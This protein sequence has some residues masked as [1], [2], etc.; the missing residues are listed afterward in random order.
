MT[1]LNETAIAALRQVLTDAAAVR[2]FTVQQAPDVVQQMLQWKFTESTIYCVFPSALLL[3]LLVLLRKLWKILPADAEYGTWGKL[4]A[5]FMPYAL[6]GSCAV[7]GA[8]TIALRMLNLTWLRILIAPKLY[9]M[10]YVV[11]TLK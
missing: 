3:G 4:D 8:T 7:F 11:E 6:F 10:E 1:N 2:D 9:I 5:V